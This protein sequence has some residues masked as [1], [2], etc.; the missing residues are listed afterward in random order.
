MEEAAPHLPRAQSGNLLLRTCGGGRPTHLTRLLP[1]GATAAVAAAAD[2][3]ALA[4]FTK[5][6]GL[7]D[8][9]Q[10]QQQRARLSMRRGGMGVRRHHPR[11]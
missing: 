4:T 10:L 3:A 7:D 9:T 5:L 11:R 6:A 1:P 8:L 2:D